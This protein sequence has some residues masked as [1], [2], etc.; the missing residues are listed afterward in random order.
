MKSQTPK[1]RLKRLLYEIN[2][3]PDFVGSK[4][5]TGHDSNLLGNT[6][7]HAAAI[8]GDLDAIALLIENGGDPNAVGEYGFTPL[9]Q[10][11]AQGNIDAALF[12]IEKGASLKLEN[13]FGK[14][15]F[16]MAEDRGAECLKR[17][18]MAGSGK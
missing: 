15:A 2:R 11:L 7:L 5:K 12:L 3:L 18:L 13:G 4:L 6:P 10:A 17:V 1:K 8:W 9:H 14:T 16:Q